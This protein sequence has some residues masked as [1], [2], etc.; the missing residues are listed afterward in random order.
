MSNGNVQTQR[1]PSGGG[2]AVPDGTNDDERGRGAKTALI[3]YLCLV[4]ILLLGMLTFIGLFLHAIATYQD[5][6]P[7]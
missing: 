1:D 4:G 3:V 7:V 5:W 6:I 2:P